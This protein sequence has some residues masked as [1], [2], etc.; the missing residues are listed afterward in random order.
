MR[1]FA[2][3]TIRARGTMLGTTKE[4]RARLVDQREMVSPSP[5]LGGLSHARHLGN[6]SATD[7]TSDVCFSLFLIGFDVSPHR[8]FV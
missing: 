3:M 7:E 1:H 8:F 6:Q 2:T 4:A 5:G